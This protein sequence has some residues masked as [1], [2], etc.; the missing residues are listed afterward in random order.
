[1]CNK[2]LFAP[3]KG[4]EGFYEIS[5]LGNVRS[6][7]RYANH[8]K[9]GYKR[10][11][12]GILL[13]PV[14]NK[15]RGNYLH[16]TLVGPESKRK[17]FRIHRLVA[18][19]FLLNPN[20]YKE[21][22]HKDFD[23]TNNNVDNLEWCDSAY[24][25]GYSKHRRPDMRGKYGRRITAYN[26]AGAVVG[27]YGSVRDAARELCCHGQNICAVLSGKNKYCKGYTFSDVQKMEPV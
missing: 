5:N 16:I 3:V 23:P 26:K 11:I 18:Q 24:N 6:V 17:T 15:A 1:M 9:D 20:E 12:Y 4:Y 21:V 13:A 25:L 8:S 10:I 2:E 22:N 7:A 19:A 27:E 14:K